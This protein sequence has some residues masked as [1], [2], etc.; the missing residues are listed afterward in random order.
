MKFPKSIL[1]Y[2]S[3]NVAF[4]SYLRLSVLMAIVSMAMTLSFHL[5]EKPTTLEKHIAKPLGAIFWL[6]ALS[7]FSVG[8]S[9]YIRMFCFSTVHYLSY[10]H[11]TDVWQKGTVNLYSQRA[12]IVQ[13]GW[14]TQTVRVHRLPFITVTYDLLIKSKKKQ[15]LTVLSAAIFGTCIVLLVINTVRDSANASQ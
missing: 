8:I 13:S 1:T 5:K 11:L 15:I 2:R 3:Q 7:T 12:A 6:L 9:N 14:R 10:V 4:L